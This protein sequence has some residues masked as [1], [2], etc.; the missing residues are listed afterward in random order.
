MSE[1]AE[2]AQLPLAEERLE[3]EE[4]SIVVLTPHDPR[5]PGHWSGTPYFLVA[6]LRRRYSNVTILSGRRL[7]WLF[8]AIRRLLRPWRIDPFRE[9]LTARVFGRLMASR[10]ERLQPDLIFGVAASHLIASLETDVP[11]IHFSDATFE[12]FIGYHG[13]YTGLAR[14]TV[15]EGNRMER[16]ALQRADA[17]LMPSEWAATSAVEDYAVPRER[18]VVAPLG[19]NLDTWP[20]P[21][22]EALQAEVCRLLF[23]G[24]DWVWKGGDLAYEVLQLL[25]SR[26]L[27]TELHIVGCD[28]PLAPDTVGVHRH[29]FLRKSEPH[30]FE[31]LKRLYGT[32]SFF[33]LPTR[34]E[35]YGLVFAEASAF[36]LPVLGRRTGGVPAVVEEGVNGMLFEPEAGAAAYADWIEAVWH[37]RAAYR[38]LRETTRAKFERDLN[39]SVWGDRTSALIDAVI[40]RRRSSAVKEGTPV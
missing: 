22:P 21:D 36:G 20:H 3:L 35:A 32:S 18:L 28:P 9:M 8:K 29:G 13:T 15:R 4:R 25:L 6:E 23:V 16:A 31:Q 38:R 39:W 11:I 24:T 19:A 26:D 1:F 27:P 17:V 5:E 33:L 34:A 30:E 10:I 14:R 12:Q 40:A 2:G 7:G 37:D